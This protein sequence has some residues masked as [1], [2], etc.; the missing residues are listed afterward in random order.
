[1]A[2][3]VMTGPGPSAEE[4]DLF[5]RSD[6]VAAVTGAAGRPYHL[7]EWGQAVLDAVADGANRRGR[8]LVDGPL[9]DTLTNTATCLGLPASPF[10]GMVEA[11]RSVIDVYQA[12]KQDLSE[13]VELREQVLGAVLEDLAA[14]VIEQLR[15]TTWRHLEAH[16]AVREQP[17]APPVVGVDLW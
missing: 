4:T 3:H 11:P 12:H 1:M 16:G 9:F 5:T 13:S 8:R 6:L 15:G 10:E 2:G 17:P 14:L 7:R